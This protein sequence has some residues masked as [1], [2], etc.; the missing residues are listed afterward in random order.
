VFCSKCGLKFD[1]QEANCPRCGQPAGAALPPLTTDEIEY[2]N[3]DRIMRRLSRYWYLFAALS[4]G[5]GATGLFMVMTG[6][7]TT[8][9]PWEPWPH[10]P[11]WNWTFAGHAAWMIVIVRVV[12]SLAAAW[13]LGHRTD[14][15]RPVAV[16]AG[17][18]ALLQFPIGAVLG[19]YTLLELLVRRRG[20]LR[21]LAS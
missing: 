13:G 8:V 15:A 14:W 5:L 7:T 12:L 6:L 9:G 21:H 11:A 19:V 20:V 2:A 4:F 18:F 17:A 1:E 16:A 3:A 10:P